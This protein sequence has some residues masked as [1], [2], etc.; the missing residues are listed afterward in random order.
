[1]EASP[2]KAPVDDV[3]QHSS[4]EEGSDVERPKGPGEM[5]PDLDMD[6]KEQDRWLPIANGE[7]IHFSR[8]H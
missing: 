7:F 6:V 4:A 5:D 1:M 3:A 2:D 8:R